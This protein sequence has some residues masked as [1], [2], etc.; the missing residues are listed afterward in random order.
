MANDPAH[1]NP[2]DNVAFQVVPL[3]SVVMARISTAPEP[4]DTESGI[5]P[6]HR[7]DA[8][9]VTVL[10]V[11]S[12]V[13]RIIRDAPLPDPGMFVNDHDVTFPERARVK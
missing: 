4:V 13:M 11:L 12:W 10:G 9:H 8:G 7:N 3:S 6:D 2:F 5:P 1:A